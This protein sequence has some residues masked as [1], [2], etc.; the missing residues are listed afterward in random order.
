MRN[1]GLKKIQG[2]SLLWDLSVFDV[3]IHIGLSLQDFPNLLDQSHFFPLI[4][5]LL[6]LTDGEMSREAITRG[7][8]SKHF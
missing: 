2:V 8:H 4:N 6:C 1:A 3:L 7:S 5:K